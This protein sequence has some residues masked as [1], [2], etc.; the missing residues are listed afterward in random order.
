MIHSLHG[1]LDIHIFYFT[2]YL[3]IN[4]VQFSS[5]TQSCLTFCEP[6]D[7][8]M[9]GFP[10]HHKLLKLAQTHV[11]QI[12]D[13]IQP[14]HPM[15]FPSPPAFNLSQHQG[16]LQGVSSLHLVG[17]VLEFQLQHESFQ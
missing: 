6:M 8:S 10:V 2:G 13:V 12:S 17:K 1:I 16:L 11:H 9:P 7:C 3:K 15:S 5:V 14:S 4:L